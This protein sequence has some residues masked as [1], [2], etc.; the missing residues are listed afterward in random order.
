V[1]T[2]FTAFDLQELVEL[3]DLGLAAEITL[4]VIRE[5]RQRRRK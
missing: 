5:V 2:S 4:K 3:K 1:S